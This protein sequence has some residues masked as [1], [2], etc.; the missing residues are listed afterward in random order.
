M[1]WLVRLLQRAVINRNVNVSERVTTNHACR[2]AEAASK[3]VTVLSGNR[4]I[5]NHGSVRVNRQ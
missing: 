3:N 4:R 2:D 1:P 5:N